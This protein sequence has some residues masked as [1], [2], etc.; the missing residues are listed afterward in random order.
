MLPSPTI[1]AV[2]QL[3]A[4]KL[5]MKC[6]R[7]F[8]EFGDEVIVDADLTT[9]R[10]LCSAG[11]DYVGAKIVM[12]P[13]A[14]AHPVTAAASSASPEPVQAMITAA[15]PSAG[16][17]DDEDVDELAVEHVVLPNEKGAIGWLSLGGGRMALWHRPGGK[18]CA[19]LCAVANATLVVTLLSERE[20]AEGIGRNAIA[21]GLEW[22]WFPLDGADAEYLE[23]E[24]AVETLRRAAVAVTDALRT[25]ASVLVHCSAGIHRTGCVAYAVLRMCGFSVAQSRAALAAMRPITGEEVD[26]AAPGRSKGG[27]RTGII[28]SR[29]L[30]RASQCRA[31]SASRACDS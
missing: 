26:H 9:E 23:T 15:A 14:P 5:R 25:G 10:I 6:T 13:P 24:D 12:S 19:K 4:N 17:Y 29:V 27:G 16:A 28:E 7:L 21:A 30:P 18:A 3:A 22:R 2:K 31:S 20:G 8:A 1:A 11:E